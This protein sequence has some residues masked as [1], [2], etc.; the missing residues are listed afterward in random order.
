MNLINVKAIDPQ[1]IEWLPKLTP[2]NLSFM[3]TSFP[4]VRQALVATFGAFPIQ[5]NVFEHQTVLAGMMAA[6]GEGGAPYIAL[7]EGLRK[8]GELEIRLT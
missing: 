6:A 8:Y 3:G 4:A 7:L 5:L 1:H 2:Q